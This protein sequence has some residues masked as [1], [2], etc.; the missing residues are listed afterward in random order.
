MNEVS[1]CYAT[2]INGAMT[3]THLCAACALG[4]GY[5]LMSLLQLNKLMKE[6]EQ[7]LANGRYRMPAEQSANKPAS[8]MACDCEN[9]KVTCGEDR[10]DEDMTK[11]REL[12][13]QMRTAINSEDYEK[14]AEIRDRI[15]QLELI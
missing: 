6:N 9:P 5:D 8:S 7:V 13:L 4:V 11:C 14:A 1:F 10:V 3:E 15:K 2:N 12:N